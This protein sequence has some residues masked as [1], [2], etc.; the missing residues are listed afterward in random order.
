MPA[1]TPKT[2]LP[3][4]QTQ[5]LPS[6]LKRPSPTA[7]GRGRGAKRKT[8]R[9]HGFRT[10]KS[11]AL[12]GVPVTV[13]QSTPLI[14]S[15][16]PL[17]HILSSASPPRPSFPETY[18]LEDA[19]GIGAGSSGLGGGRLGGRGAGSARLLAGV[20][21]RLSSASHPSRPTREGGGKR[22]GPGGGRAAGGGWLREGRGSS[23]VLRAVV[24]QG[25]SGA[26]TPEPCPPQ[27]QA[28][29]VPFA[30]GGGWR[31]AVGC[32]LGALCQ[33]SPGSTASSP[34]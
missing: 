7:R 8:V 25:S 12:G 32:V 10:P 24:A 28:C 14:P 9:S 22:E 21:W 31:E 4:T 26:A 13:A 11:P 33:A 18:G 34:P 6:F 3:Q 27:L 2:C 29:E 20:C 5:A 15:P 30:D 1:K 19:P 23:S 17:T 16:E